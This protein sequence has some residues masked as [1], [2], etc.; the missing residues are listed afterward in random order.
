[1]DPIENKNQ[2][3]YL[4]CAF[5]RTNDS[6]DDE[7]INDVKDSIAELNDTVTNKVLPR[8][9]YQSMALRSIQNQINE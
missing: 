4:I 9:F 8:I 5:L 2:I 1:M 6:A 7:A 3:S